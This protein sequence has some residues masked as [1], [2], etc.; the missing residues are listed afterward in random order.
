MMQSLASEIYFG[1]GSGLCFRDQP[2]IRTLW[3]LSRH[4]MEFDEFEEDFMRR[5]TNAMDKIQNFVS[6]FHEDFP[7]D[8]M[9]TIKHGPVLSQAAGPSTAGVM[10]IRELDKKDKFELALDV[11]DFSLEDLTVKLVGRKLVITGVK[12]GQKACKFTKE[13]D[14]PRHTNLP[15]LTCSLTS[16]SL[17]KIEAPSLQ[18]PEAAERTVPIRFRTSLNVPVSNSQKTGQDSTEKTA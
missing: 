4:K 12:Q 10:K 6:Q 18:Q 9:K 11:R 15:A 8:L 1:T 13:I 5:R 14:L 3:P 7:D 16:D 2:R 17:L